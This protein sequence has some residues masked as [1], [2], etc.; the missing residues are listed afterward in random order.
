[1]HS[2]LDFS[3]DPWPAISESAKD[4]V[5][6]VLVR[7]PTKRITAYEVL[8]KIEIKVI[9]LIPHLACDYILVYFFFR[10]TLFILLDYNSFL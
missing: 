5:R 9:S 10:T 7:D 1:M 3:S 6:K 8:R 4:L 2:E